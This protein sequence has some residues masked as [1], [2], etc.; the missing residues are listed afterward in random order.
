MKESSPAKSARSAHGTTHTRVYT[1]LKSAL[2]N[3]DFVPGQRLVVRQ[4]AERL[5]TSP[6]PVREALRRLVSDEALFD[7]PNKG[8]IVPDATVEVI[9][10]LVRVRSSIEGAAAEWA[11][12]TI[13]PDELDAIIGLN[14]A[15]KECAAKGKTANYLVLNRQFHFAIYRAARSA[16]LQ[17]V[18]ERL[19]LRAGPWLNIMR[20]EATLG[21]GLDHHEEILEGLRTADGP[22][23]RR[24]LVA[25]IADAAD[26]ML[27]A[28][29]GSPI[30]SKTERVG[31]APRRFASAAGAR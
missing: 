2:M 14:D 25:D 17:P 11:A 21:Q 24:A 26:I 19:W 9:S 12:T 16:V 13:L 7:H 28:A 31:A 30:V 20:G 8:V 4:L 1:E 23:A 29:S 22:M 27:R 3:G 15:M 5:E 18:I 10:D 6:M